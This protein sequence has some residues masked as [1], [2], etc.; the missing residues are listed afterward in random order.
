MITQIT[1]EFLK[2][3]S[4]K[5]LKNIQ[6]FD[7]T[8]NINLEKSLIYEINIKTNNLPSYKIIQIIYIFENDIKKSFLIPIYQNINN[9]FYSGNE[10]FN[11]SVHIIF[12]NNKTNPISNEECNVMYEDKTF[13]PKNIFS[14]IKNRKCI[15]FININIEDLKLGGELIKKEGDFIINIILEEEKRKII[16]QYDIK[17]EEFKNNNFDK[18][19]T[20][21][22]IEEL[23]EVLEK[24]FFSKKDVND[25]NIFLSKTALN[26]EQLINYNKIIR[27]KANSLI[28][29]IYRNYFHSYK[30]NLDEDDLKLY[31]LISELLLIGISPK[32]V[33]YIYFKQYY[34]SIN[35]FKKFLSSIPSYIDKINNLKL[36]L[37]V[38]KAINDYFNDSF[39]NGK[40]SFEFEFLDLNKNSLYFDAKKK[41]IEFIDN[42]TEESVVF[43]YFLF[44]NSG[45]STNLLNTD[46]LAAKTSMISVQDIQNHL[47]KSLP[48]YSIKGKISSKYKAVTYLE[49][50]IIIFNEEKMFPDYFDDS[51]EDL[52]KFIITNIIK[53]E[54]FGHI[55]FQ[56]YDAENNDG[57]PS[58]PIQFYDL[59][60][61][62]LINL[63]VKD[64]EKFKGEAG[65]SF[66]YF[67]AQGD[68]DI[69]YFIR[70]PFGNCKE[71]FVKS[72]LKNKSEYEEFI[73]II[74]ERIEENNI[75][76]MGNKI[77]SNLDK[78]YNY[79]LDE[80]NY[81][82][83]NVI[84]PQSIK[85]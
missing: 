14:S 26:R 84:N 43:P 44:I 80:D 69:L 13:F 29:D 38:A 22:E 12:Q 53:H 54:S 17:V 79:C 72:G 71:L 31:E 18:K 11:N 41:C 59:K 3:S 16:G 4:N 8:V 63:K 56:L 49:T 37:T 45:V 61:K 34:Y 51:D 2:K 32:N 6:I 58:S 1:I 64:K 52:D 28:L 70:N 33:P 19:K 27:N 67:E 65:A 42:L 21:K 50:N 46:F 25:K 36:K 7:Y 78:K 74:K 10:I 57:F 30:E 35:Q 77:I 66:E 47:Y 83:G 60:K 76:E 15:N 82:T 39:I 40:Y 62:E 68:L 24:D 23:F 9:Y 85:Y 73:N 75:D 5:L 55:K 81:S 48:S 20:I